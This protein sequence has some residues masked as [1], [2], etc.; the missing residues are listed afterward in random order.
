MNRLFLIAV[1][2]IA[3]L[4]CG[5]PKT[6]D[7]SQK[8]S[9]AKSAPEKEEKAKGEAN[10][11]EI[12][13]EAQQRAGIVVTPV[14]RV[15]MTQFLQLTG[16]VQPV[17]SSVAHV[18]PLARGRL[19]E[20]RVKLGDRVAT[21]QIL[22]QFDNIEAGELIPQYNTARSELQ[23]L[24]IQLAAQQRQVERN[25]RLAEIGAAPE[26][27]YEFSL[28][29][30]QGLEESIKAQESTIAGLSARLR[31][32]GIDA[33]DAS[34][35]SATSIRAPSAGVVIHMDAAPGEVV[36]TATDLFTVADLSTVYVQGQVYEKDLA[37]VRPGQTVSITVD[38]YAAQPFSGR[39]ASISALIDPQTRTAAVRCLV[40]N[41]SA[42]LKL[43]MLAAIRFPTSSK[44]AVL[45]VPTDAVQ[46]IDNKTVVFVQ[47]APTQFEVR[48]VE[49]G[50]ASE[51][52][53]EIVRGLRE[54]DPIVSRGA[55]AVKSVL[56][57]KE[58]GEKE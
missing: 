29:E 19:Q 25:R 10:A 6:A 40:D 3:F 43:D 21:G 13:S 26:K 24:K 17:D 38:S 14:A 11:I 53:T 31:R 51:G 45:S 32:F 9:Q 50:V 55:F 4:S 41:S 42:S 23:K 8:E 47:T 34:A 1:C 15:P 52:R 57:A 28:A 49:T 33:A 12:S 7:E 37:Q 56:L 46:T 44:R 20:V 30:Q 2:C 58:L 35:S 39:V 27:D 22:A 36:E 54:T 48:P 16:S 5:K 18:R